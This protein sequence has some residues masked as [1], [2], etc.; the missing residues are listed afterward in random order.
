MPAIYVGS[1][2]RSLRV[3]EF[4]GKVRE[5]KVDPLRVIWHGGSGHAFLQFEKSE[6]AEDAL[7]AL[8]GL[9]LNGKEVKVEMSNNSR[10]RKKSDSQDTRE[11]DNESMP[12]KRNSE[13][14]DQD[15]A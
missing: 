10:G 11:M 3:S 5:Q 2:P 4:K 7:K 14:V 6:E 9:I 12:N 8:E 15:E 1:L 13:Y